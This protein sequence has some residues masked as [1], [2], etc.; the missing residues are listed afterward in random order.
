VASTFN[1]FPSQTNGRPP[2]MFATLLAFTNLPIHTLAPILGLLNATSRANLP[3]FITLLAS[4]AMQNVDITPLV[5]FGTQNPTFLN[6]LA[7]D[8]EMLKFLQANPSIFASLIPTLEDPA[9]LAAYL[10]SVLA[11]FLSA[12]SMTNPSES[13]SVISLL[14]SLANS[15]LATNNPEANPLSALLKD[16]LRDQE[17]RKQQQQEENENQETGENSADLEGSKPTPPKTPQ[18]P[19]GHHSHENHKFN[20]SSS[21]SSIGSPTPLGGSLSTHFLEKLDF[22][23][24]SKAGSKAKLGDLDPHN[25][26]QMDLVIAFWEH[27]DYEQLLMDIQLLH[28]TPF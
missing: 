12:G 5:N 4:P 28:L 19:N 16:I 21:S 8:S 18:S 10:P 22:E 20:S 9:S 25:S 15:T 1:F 26:Y 11:A 17:E 3:Q 13:I 2:G 6:Q 14:S 7:S 27:V 23:E 24:V